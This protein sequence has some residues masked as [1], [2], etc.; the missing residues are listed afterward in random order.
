MVWLPTAPMTSPGTFIVGPV[1]P[2]GF[3]SMYHF[4]A[5]SRV[6]LLS[7]SSVTAVIKT[8]LGVSGGR[9]GSGSRHGHQRRGVGGRGAHIH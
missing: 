4:M 7:L 9:P 8:K 6:P 2:T 5:T 3:P 1:T